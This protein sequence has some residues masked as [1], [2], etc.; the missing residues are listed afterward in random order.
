MQSCP[1]ENETQHYRPWRGFGPVTDGESLLFAVFE[2]TRREEKSLTQKSFEDS[3]LR[4]IQ[5]SVAR[6]KYTTRKNFEKNIVTPALGS[7]GRLI[8]ISRTTA[9]NLRSLKCYYKLNNGQ[10]S[11]FR[12]LI[13]VDSVKERDF[14]SHATIGYCRDDEPPG[15]GTTQLGRSRAILRLNIVEAFS[16]ITPIDDIIWPTGNDVL[17]SRVRYCFNRFFSA[18]SLSTSG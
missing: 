1:L 8:G 17:R 16:Q 14:D 2:N 3:H 13:V 7:K 15:I 18:N 12:G 10:T 6:A 5:L 11:S 9:G 4:R